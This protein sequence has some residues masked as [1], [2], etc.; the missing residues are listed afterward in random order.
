MNTIKLGSK[1]DDVKRLQQALGVTPC[2][3]ICGGMTVNA[4][5]AF[6]LRV[7]LTPVDGIAGPKTLAALFPS[8]AGGVT[9]HSPA[10]PS[11]PSAGGVSTTSSA[12]TTV[13]V[14]S[15]LGIISKPLPSSLFNT[16]TT[17]IRYIVI[18]YTAGAS[19]K[20][21]NA[22]KQYNVFLTRKVSSDFVVDDAT[23]YQFNPNP[24]K[25]AAKT[26]GDST[27]YRATN[28][29]IA[30][31]AGAVP[32]GS[33][34]GLVRNAD[35]VSIEVCCNLQKGA[36]SALPNHTGW[37]FTEASLKRAAALAR[38]LMKL[39]N[40]PA[41]R[42]IRHYDV[43]HKLCPGIIGW[44]EG[45]IYTTGGVATAQRSTS[46]EWKLFKKLLS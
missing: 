3:G 25:Y 15:A 38:H 31:A 16:R 22:L 21:G 24:A 23:I 35:C 5:K 17:P 26:V 13:P 18:H 37:T 40:I 8:S 4:I 1:G 29:N 9:T 41:W 43:T 10:S 36:N 28:A 19:S 39:Y 27:N 12:S 42:V 33:P 7:G 45:R 20:S 11:A 34:T 14:A 2:D 46:Q 6:Q 30:A 32:V 44:N